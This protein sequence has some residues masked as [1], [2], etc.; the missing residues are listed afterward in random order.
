MGNATQER[1]VLASSTLGKRPL[2]VQKFGGTSVGDVAR[3]KRV[4]YQS[5]HP[6]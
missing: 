2:V 4:A 5:T 1:A 3:I 6:T